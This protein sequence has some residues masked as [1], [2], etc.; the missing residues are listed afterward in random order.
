MFILLGMGLIVILTY[1]V[2]SE[3]NRLPLRRVSS[4]GGGGG[5]DETTG[6]N[7][8][9][10]CVGARIIQSNVTCIAISRKQAQ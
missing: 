2:G 7:Q 10:A 1:Y 6:L 9:C 5:G 8:I 3:V 4:G